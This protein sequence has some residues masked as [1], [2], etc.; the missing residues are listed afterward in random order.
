MGGWV[1]WVV[2]CEWCVGRVWLVGWTG[3]GVVSQSWVVAVRWGEGQEKGWLGGFWGL[4]ALLAMA[5]GLHEMAGNS[6]DAYMWVCGGR[7]CG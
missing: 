5:G 2:G 1:G 4:R 3:R 7:L 6:E